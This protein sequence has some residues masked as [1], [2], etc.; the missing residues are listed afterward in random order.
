MSGFRFNLALTCM[1]TG[2]FKTCRADAA[3]IVP[4]QS[5]DIQGDKSIVV[6]RRSPL[7]TMPLYA[8][9]RQENIFQAII[10]PTSGETPASQPPG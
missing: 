2:T 4:W 9:A 3:T 10:D 1:G 6:L 7:L 5:F 8:F